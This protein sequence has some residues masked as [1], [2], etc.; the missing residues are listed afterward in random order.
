MHYWARYWGHVFRRAGKEAWTYA[1]AHTL[2]T[3]T[4]IGGVWAATTYATIQAT[5]ST[6]QPLT[7]GAA[8]HSAAVS[9]ALLAGVALTLTVLRALIWLPA[10][11][12]AEGFRVGHLSSLRILVDTSV[13]AAE[14]ATLFVQIINNSHQDAV[15]LTFV[16]GLEGT[17]RRWAPCD[18]PRAI[19]MAIC[20]LGSGAHPLDPG[21]TKALPLNPHIAPQSKIEGWI[22]FES[23]ANIRS[24]LFGKPVAPDPDEPGEFSVTKEN[25]FAV[26]LYVTDRASGY[27]IA[28]P[29]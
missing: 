20:H 16:L 26:R 15:L 12:S 1:G 14:E 11:L 8:L 21:M 25:C 28:V 29:L 18:E 6:S 10:K 4:V 9:L 2:G 27:S 24:R 22:T 23:R 19:S 17:K 5:K 7:W 13:L 3:L